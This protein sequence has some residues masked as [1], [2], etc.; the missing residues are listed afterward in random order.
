MVCQAKV[1]GCGGGEKSTDEGK[2]T[3]RAPM[4]HIQV[5][6]TRDA[7]KEEGKSTKKKKKKAAEVEPE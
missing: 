3:R 7:P 1:G 6:E 4:E 5:S 2:K